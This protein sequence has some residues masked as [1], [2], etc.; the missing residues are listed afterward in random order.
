MH[1]IDFTRFNNF[2]T[3]VFA[4][5]SSLNLCSRMKG[6]NFKVCFVCWPRPWVKE[7]F[8]SRCLSWILH[9]LSF[10]SS[11]DVQDTFSRK[12]NSFNEISFKTFIILWRTYWM[13]L[14]NA[15]SYKSWRISLG[16]EGHFIPSGSH[17]NKV[18][19]CYKNLVCN[20]YKCKK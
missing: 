4:F 20:V 2:F 16:G 11:L 1:I 7:V 10:R 5:D 15:P 3:S 12:F 9:G 14:G 13:S 17:M 8:S 6:R 19:D 18:L